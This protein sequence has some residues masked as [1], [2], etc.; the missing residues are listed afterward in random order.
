M[1]PERRAELRKVVASYQA[2]SK[3]D[4]DTWWRM[5]AE[6]LYELDDRDAMLVRLYTDHVNT[7]GACPECGGDVGHIDGCKLLPIILEAP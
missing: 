7:T 1:T 5:V 2:T 4:D 6:L 3:Y